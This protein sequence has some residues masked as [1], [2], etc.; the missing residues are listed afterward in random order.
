MNLNFTIA[1]GQLKTW[2]FLRIDMKLFNVNHA[3]IHNNKTRYTFYAYV[4]YLMNFK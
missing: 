3:M 2:R 1:C 4:F